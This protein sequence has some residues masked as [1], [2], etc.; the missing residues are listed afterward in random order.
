MR[1]NFI[2]TNY[3]CQILY[4]YEKNGNQEMIIGENSLN[5][6]LYYR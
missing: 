2:K 3:K 1:L 4:V 5:I 6:N